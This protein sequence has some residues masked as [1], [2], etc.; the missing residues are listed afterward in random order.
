MARKYIYLDAETI[1]DGDIEDF[2]LYKEP[3]KNFK[4]PEKFK[5][6]KMNKKKSN[7]LNNLLIPT[8]LSY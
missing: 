3:P 2:E 5:L 6:G 1:P 7:F 8:E 4:D